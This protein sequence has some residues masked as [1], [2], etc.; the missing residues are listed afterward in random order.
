MKK[1]V[2]KLQLSRET[3]QTLADDAREL[4]VAGAIFTATPFCSQHMIC[5]VSCG[6]DCT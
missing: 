3:V 2:K 1:I 4:R 5:T 6:I